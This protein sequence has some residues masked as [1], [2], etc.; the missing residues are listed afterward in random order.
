MSRGSPLNDADRAP[1][2]ASLSTSI[3]TIVSRGNTQRAVLACSALKPQ[4]R[5]VLRGGSPHG[6]VVFVLLEPSVEDLERRVFERQSMHFMAPSL[7]Q[8]QVDAL[9]Y[10]V[11]ELFMHFTGASMNSAPEGVAAEVVGRLLLER[12]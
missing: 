5:D 1:W 4:Y 6:S 8:S 3:S 11:D 9:E 10:S 2:L 7:L 12:E